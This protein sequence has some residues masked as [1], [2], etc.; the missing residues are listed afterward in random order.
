[1]AR[2]P[3]DTYAKDLALAMLAP[4]GAAESDARS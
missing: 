1:M 4:F 3:F 2:T